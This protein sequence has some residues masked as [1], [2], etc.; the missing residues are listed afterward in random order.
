MDVK[1]KILLGAAAIDARDAFDP[2]ERREYMNAS[3]A[4]TCIRKQW[5]AK[6]NEDA[7]EEQDWGYARRGNGVEKHVV[8]C[9]LAANVDLRL[10]GEDQEG[11]YS[12][13][14]RIS[15]TPD[16]VFVEP[17]YLIGGEFKSIDPRVNRN[18]LPR[19]YNVTQLQ[20]GMALVD[21]VKVELG[22]PDLP[23]SHGLL[24]YTDASN[25][26][27]TIQFTVPF[28]PDILDRLAKRA[29]RLLGTR[30]VARLPREGKMG[31]GKECNTMCSFKAQCMGDEAAV[32]GTTQSG[33]GNKGSRLDIVVQDYW[34]AKLIE[35][36]AKGD[37][38]E[39]AE[40]IKQE[41]RKRK[42]STLTVGGR[43]VELVSVKGRLSLDKKAVKAK[44]IDLTPFEKRGAASERLTIK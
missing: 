23:F 16:G 13:E 15:A 14:H 6:F 26:N 5:Y 1:R 19:E 41:L 44:G 34:A 31:G 24:T 30:S 27:D 25:W 38:D 9:L 28:D 32:D 21:R 11:V 29:K 35:L 10:A 20:L 33:R 40:R 39:A 3:E 7:G 37:K 43:S 42:V 2:E 17:E 12:D 8:A 18:N 22:L 36:S 4:M